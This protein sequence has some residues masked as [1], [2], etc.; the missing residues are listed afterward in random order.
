[1]PINIPN[2]LPA[3]SVLSGENIFVMYERKAV[4]QDIRALRIAIL[5]LMP[6]KITTET[7]L[8]RLLSNSPLQVDITLLHPRTY[9]S[10]NT[11]KEHFIMFYRTF[12]DVRDERFDGLIITGAPVENMEFEDVAYWDELTE[13]M[14]WSKR[15]VFSTFH[16]C[17]GAQAGLY[18]H[19]GVRKH[20]LAK[21]LSGVYGHKKCAGN[22]PLLRGFDEE[23][24]VPHSRYTTV[25]RDEVMAVPA[26]RLISE[27][28][29]A[30]VYIVTAGDGRMVFVTGH[31]EYDDLTLK[32]EYDRDL[33]KSPDVE[34][35]V[36]YFPGDDPGRAP[37]V[38]WKAHANLLYGNWLNYCVYQETKFDL[39]KMKEL[40]F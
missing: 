36:N 11:P 19:F 38:R 34:P 39:R 10:K 1:M 29:E 14:D 9:V 13:I 8:L 32:A 30:G 20:P 7:Q 25:L 4:R 24:L 35:P 21:K 12:D 37:M 27:S 6:T 3:A 15:N 33:E 5:N 31:P 40:A 28:D 17:W 23:F 22:I 26:L 16:I 2:K 18:R